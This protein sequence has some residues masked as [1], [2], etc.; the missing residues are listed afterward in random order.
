MLQKLAVIDAHDPFVY[1]FRL[2]IQKLSKP[3]GRIEGPRT[4]RD[5]RTL[6]S[7]FILDMMP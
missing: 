5:G 1:V 2:V 7:M 3:E 4:Q 6:Q